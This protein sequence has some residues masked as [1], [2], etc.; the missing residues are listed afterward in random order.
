MGAPLKYHWKNNGFDPETA[1]LNT[2]SPPSLTDCASGCRVNF[3]PWLT[4][5]KAS[6]RTALIWFA[7]STAYRPF[8]SWR[9][10]FNTSSSP[11]SSGS[12]LPSKNH[13]YVNGR[14]PSASTLRTTSVPTRTV[15]SFRP[16]MIS[17]GRFSDSRAGSLTNSP[18][19]LAKRTWY[20]PA[21]GRWTDG[22]SSTIESSPSISSPSLYHST[23]IGSVPVTIRTNLCGSPRLIVAEFSPPSSTGGSRTFNKAT[24]LRVLP[25][26]L[27]T[28]TS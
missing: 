2:A 13:R 19:A 18:P 25:R 15:R 23:A 6:L 14:A 10:L 1:T 28:S 8:C 9:M 22:R 5:R 17:T 27:A 20:R 26:L 16:V 12:S 24:L 21:S 11:F 4:L 7:T 3:G